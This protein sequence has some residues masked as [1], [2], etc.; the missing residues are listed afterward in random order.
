MKFL[1]IKLK[2]VFLIEI[3]SRN[4]ATIYDVILYK[5]KIPKNK[6]K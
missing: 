4:M 2:D 5:T 1:F 6:K 3:L